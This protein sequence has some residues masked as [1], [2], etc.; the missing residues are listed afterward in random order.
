MKRSM[1]F[2]FVFATAMAFGG[3][4]LAQSTGAPQEKQGMTETHSKKPMK[5]KATKSTTKAHAMK[6][7]STKTHSAKTH[8]M[9]KSASHHKSKKTSS[10][11][12]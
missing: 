2:A 10:K 5:A 11:K 12:S 6:A 3:M 9:H 1:L 8:A 4:A 7:S